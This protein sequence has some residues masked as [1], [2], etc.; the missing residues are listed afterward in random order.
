M[1]EQYVTLAIIVTN[2]G[3]ASPTIAKSSLGEGMEM[4]YPL[5]PFLFK[6]SIIIYPAT[7]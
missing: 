2:T 4:A 7:T 3:A 1:M 5:Y 6:A